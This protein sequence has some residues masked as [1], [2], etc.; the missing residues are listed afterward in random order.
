MVEKKESIIIGKIIEKVFSTNKN[1]NRIAHD[2][3]FEETG[4]EI[5]N[6]TNTQYFIGWLIYHFVFPGGKNFIPY[7]KETIVLD[8]EEKDMIQ[9][10]ENGIL[11]TFEVL[12]WGNIVKVK[13][14]LTQKEYAVSVIDMKN[15]NC[16]II[17]AQLVKSLDNNY[18][19]FGGIGGYPKT[20]EE[21]I[22]K[23]VEEFNNG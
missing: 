3:F 7:V 22:Q 15:P 16:K 17:T 2:E 1:I 18:F 14:L 9:R 13:D 8:E 12:E 5:T 21:E 6:P 19:F 20:K 23:Y 4:I 10:L 11:G